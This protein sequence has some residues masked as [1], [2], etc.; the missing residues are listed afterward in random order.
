MPY[1]SSSAAYLD[2]L[3]R[4]MAYFHVFDPVLD[5]S[6][7]SVWADSPTHAK[8]RVVAQFGWV[9]YADYV[10]AA[11]NHNGTQTLEAV[12]LKVWK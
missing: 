5:A 8:N 3:E 9:S 2:L 11:V 10:K 6:H 7:G 4:D 12:E 1:T